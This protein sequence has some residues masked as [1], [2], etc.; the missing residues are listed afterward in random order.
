MGSTCYRAGYGNHRASAWPWDRLP[1]FKSIGSH[2]WV[3]GRFHITV[4]ERWVA[5]WADGRPISSSVCVAYPFHVIIR[6]LIF[7]VLL[8]SLDMYLSFRFHVLC[9]L[10]NP[11]RLCISC[12]SFGYCGL[13]CIFLTVAY[14]F[15]FLCS[16]WWCFYS[17]FPSLSSVS[18]FPL[19]SHVFLE[20]LHLCLDLRFTEELLQQYFKFTVMWLVVNFIF[21]G[22][23]LLL[24]QHFSGEWFLCYCFCCY[25]SSFLF[26]CV[27]AC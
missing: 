10:M 23:V 24:W 15:W 22:S 6:W 11:F 16:F 27:S 21:Y 3:Q 12:A 5:M 25:F 14:P 20:I 1:G 9:F 4:S 2:S 7:W 17:F 19:S 26:S 18:S 8:G 13:P